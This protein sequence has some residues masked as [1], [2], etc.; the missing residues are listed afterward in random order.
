M[1]QSLKIAV[2]SCLCLVF[3]RGAAAEDLPKITE[4]GLHLR[5]GSKL[6]VVYVDPEASLGG[7]H[8]VKLLDAAVAFRKNWLRDQ[9]SSSVDRL[10]VTSSDVERIKKDLAELF[11]E[12]FTTALEEAGYEVTD[13]TGDDVL[14]VRPAIVN[15]DVNAPD[16][17]SSGRSR[18]YTQSAGEMTLYVELYDSVTSDLLAKAIDRQSD[19]Y[20]SNYTWTNS[21][22]NR[23]AATRVLKGWAEV[24]VNALNEAQ[25]NTARE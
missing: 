14:L 4:D 13:E 6:A 11:R 12:V 16:T 8:R 2:L 19:R 10:R 24:L 7:Y 15:L 17:M 3:A 20:S 23:S 5:D 1:E 21:V 9:R 18:S 25:A 22:T